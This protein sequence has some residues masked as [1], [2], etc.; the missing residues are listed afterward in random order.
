[1]YR[2]LKKQNGL[3]GAG[4]CGGGDFS[5][6]ISHASLGFGIASS[7]GSCLSTK[8]AKAANEG[9]Q[10]RSSEL[11]SFCVLIHPPQAKP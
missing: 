6:A 8:P 2:L 1:M 10:R 5:N 7:S 4:V 3:V 11:C 9:F